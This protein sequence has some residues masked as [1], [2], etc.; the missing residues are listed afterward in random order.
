MIKNKFTSIARNAAKKQIGELKKIN[1]VFNNSFLKAIEI[2]YN[3]KGHIICS[4]IGKSAIVADRTSKLFSSVGIPS[5][6]ISA[7]NFSHGDSG[8]INTKQ[9][10]LLVFSYS[11]DSVE[12]T[13]SPTI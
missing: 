11:G 12:A 6:S 10:I 5:F 7:Q 3:C 13:L 1:R 9:D 2:I 8:A 4:G